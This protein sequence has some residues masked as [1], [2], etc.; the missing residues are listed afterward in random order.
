[1]GC[2]SVL[3]ELIELMRYVQHVIMELFMIA[4]EKYVSTVPRIVIFAQQQTI[5]N[6]AYRLALTL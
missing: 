2:V 3:M 4:T 1:M 5:V 6:S